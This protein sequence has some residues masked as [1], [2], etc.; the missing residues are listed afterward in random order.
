MIWELALNAAFG[1]KCKS[2]IMVYPRALLHSGGPMSCVFY[3]LT[4]PSNIVIIV[5]LAVPTSLL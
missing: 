3:Q 4:I 1:M 2:I 5:F